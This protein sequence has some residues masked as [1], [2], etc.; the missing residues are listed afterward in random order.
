MGAILRNASKIA[1][2]QHGVI[3]AAQLIA[4]GLS[5]SGIDKWVRKGLLHR[6]F[7]GVYRL[8]H[9]APSIHARYMA[10]VLACGPGAAL[11]GLTAAFHL[12]LVR[13]PPSLPEVSHP[14]ERA[15]PGILSRQRQIP[16]RTWQGIPTATVQ[17]V[18][19]DLAG[20]LPLDDLTRVCHEAEIKFKVKK[21]PTRG[22]RGAAKLRAIYEGD[23]ALVLSE[24]ERE[25]KR[26]L[27]TASLPLPK[28][29]RR[30]GAHYIDA[31]YTD[32]PVTI[33]LQSYKHHSSRA[34]WET[35]FERQRAARRR[36]DEFRPYTWHDVF[37]A[38]ADMVADI[39]ALLGIPAKLQ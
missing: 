9:A 28:F 38:P 34:A 20:T 29:N 23:H 5:R 35:D 22:V 26:V 16:A 37:E 36:G 18:I 25:F 1:G 6:E 27:E 19:H 33:E 39:A 15:I 10:A 13:R 21:V 2:R 11:S 12:G 32:P 14:R 4:L 17:Q 24:M 31:R 3:T 7:R 30:Q 8:G